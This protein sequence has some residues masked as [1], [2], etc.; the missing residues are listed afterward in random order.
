VGGGSRRRRRSAAPAGTAPTIDSDWTT[1][2]DRLGISP[3]NVNPDP[4][5]IAIEGAL[6]GSIRAHGLHGGRLKSQSAS[7]ESSVQRQ[8][9]GVLCRGL[10][11]KR[12]EYLRQFNSMSAIAETLQ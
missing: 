12:Q 11:I 8:Q 3:F 2:L 9:R 5:L 10:S 4:V 1:H 7:A 6:W